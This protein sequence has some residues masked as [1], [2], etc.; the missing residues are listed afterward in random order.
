MALDKK[1]GQ[2]AKE[3]VTKDAKQ[4]KTSLSAPKRI[5]SKSTK[6]PKRSPREIGRMNAPR[7]W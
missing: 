4:S 3:Q 7:A 5:K 2:E 1:V 6:V